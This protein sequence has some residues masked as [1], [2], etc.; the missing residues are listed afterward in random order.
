MLAQWLAVEVVAL[1]DGVEGLAML[2]CGDD[3]LIW[4]G[5]D[6]PVGGQ[7]DLPPVCMATTLSG[8]VD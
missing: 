1:G 8:V 3:A 2:A 7:C 6:L 4:L 5:P